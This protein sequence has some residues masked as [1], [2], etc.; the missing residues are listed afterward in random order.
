[1]AYIKNDRSG[2]V[3]ESRA[4]TG[5][6]ATTM[7]KISKTMD[8]RDF[9]WLPDGRL[10]YALG[11]PRPNND[12]CNY[13][14]VKVVT[15]TG[16]LNGTPRRMTNWAGFCLE[17][18]T[19]TSDAK[20]LAFLEWVGQS[21]VYVAEIEANG[22]RITNPKRLTL[23][24]GFNDPVSWTPDSKTIVFL[25]NR[26]GH[27]GLF[28]QALKSDVAEPIVTGPEDVED[29]RVTPD[30]AWVLYTLAGKGAEQSP[31][32]QLMRVAMGGGPSHLVLTARK[33][34]PLLCAFTLN[35]CAIAERSDDRKQLIFTAV[36]PLSGR[37]LE[38]T[39]FDADPDADYDWALSPEGKRIAVLKIPDKKIRILSLAGQRPE[40]IAVRGERTLESITWSAN[41]MGFS[42]YSQHQQRGSILLHI[43]L[44]GDAHVLWEQQGG[45]Y[46]W[47]L[48]SPNGRYLTI[49]GWTRHS[50]SWMLEHF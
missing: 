42:A 46:S 26:D 32:I 22:T 24:D 19:V 23:S 41:G 16:E 38:L 30:G 37:G 50:N 36:D 47:S 31:Q 21:N 34:G 44:Q 27:R 40:E 14:E 15:S 48:P 8:L 13:W 7:L 43:D 11:E 2:D 25:S 12:S 5:G 9:L 6:P 49:M 45:L 33:Y 29:A 3:I 17:S 4:L 10:I 39:R 1:L 28:R 35:L 20:R 18:M